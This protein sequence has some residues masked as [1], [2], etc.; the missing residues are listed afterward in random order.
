MHSRTTK[1]GSGTRG[2]NRFAA[3]PAFL[4]LAGALALFAPAAYAE[5]GADDGGDLK[6]KIQAK[7]EKILALMG[8]NEAALLKLSTGKATATKKV[9]VEVPD[10]DGKK[11][12]GSEG[13][14]G[15]AGGSGS[16]GA[17][18]ATGKSASEEITKLLETVTKKGGS[19][20]DEIKQLVEMIPL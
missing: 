3:L 19:I 18:G 17:A 16:S 13:A 9:D 5:D 11:G 4:L 14:S 10:A 8:E 15:A 20:P 12:A 7:M 2:A 1:A 6:K